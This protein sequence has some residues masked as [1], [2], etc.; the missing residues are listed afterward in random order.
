[1][2]LHVLIV[3]DSPVMRKIV[4]RV[5]GMS[6]LSI[7]AVHEAGSGEDAWD[8]LQ[9]EQNINLGLFDINMPGMGGEELTTR[10]RN[11]ERFKQLP[12][13][14]VSTERSVERRRR[15]ERLGVGF[16]HKPFEPE[17]LVES[18]TRVIGGGNQ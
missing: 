9:R 8:I 11:N 13:V 18:I 4:L 1:M 6:G 3:D 7:E 16:L 17:N 2:N 5:L 15:L 12:I 14:I 10:L